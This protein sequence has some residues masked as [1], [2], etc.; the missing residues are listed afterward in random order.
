MVLVVGPDGAGK[1]A[2]AD[3]VA[4]AAAA[5]GVPV[6]RGHF[7]P[8]ILV[9]RRG[10]GSPVCDPHGQPP[11][12]LVGSAA[13]LALTW[14]DFA[15][16]W[17]VRWRRARRAGLVVLERGWFD[18]AVDPRRYRLD[19]R[20]VPLVRA[21]GRLL[22]RADLCVVA[23]GDP[24]AVVARKPEIGVDE[25]ARQ[26]AA[27]RA[28]SGRA[29]RRVVAVDTVGTD[30]DTGARRALA[31]LEAACGRW[32]APL[33]PARM[34]LVATPGPDGAAALAV[35]RPSNRRARLAA[36]GA[37][38]QVRW[39]RAR[40]VPEPLGGL[41]GLAARIGVGSSGVAVMRSQ[42]PDRF[43]VGFAAEGRLVAVAKLGPAGD[44]ALAR[45]AE[46]LARL[47]G[48]TYPAVPRLAWVGEWE[49]RAVVAT[50][51]VAARRV[52]PRVPV[53]EAAA[54]A[55][56]LTRG[57]GGTPLVHGDFASWNFLDTPTGLVLA[58]WEAARFAAEPLRDLTDFV[59]RE[60]A[61]LGRIGPRRAVRL[62]TAPGGPGAAHLAAV[63]ADPSEAAALLA[64]HLAG[65]DGPGAPPALS[66]F[67]ARMR[68]VLG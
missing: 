41:G 19:P 6:L 44:P 30:A 62:L 13:K 53:A 52:T 43:V 18:Q 17:A 1:T 47:D 49:G 32:L 57:V 9:A 12:G 3:R 4:A 36:R 39:G 11:R 48:S 54:V 26:Q 15:L 29:G 68:E 42:S 34:D 58:D 10:D 38:G 27:W 7:A 16:G 24:A 28:L 25:T 33:T 63:G 35:Y 55:T 8:G 31:A 20:V 65:A 40:R 22:P 21:L 59:V 64:R 37:A 46:V 61:L 60:G 50:W 56:R 45:E 23:G 2:L 66:R 14:V 51:A 67:V 5:A